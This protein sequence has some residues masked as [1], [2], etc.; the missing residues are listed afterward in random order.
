MPEYYLYTQSDV[1]DTDLLSGDVAFADSY[2]QHALVNIQKLVK[3][4]V[5]R[6]FESLDQAKAQN[7][8]LYNN[9]DYI[10]MISVPETTVE[11]IKEFTFLKQGT[12]LSIKDISKLYP[13]ILAHYY[14]PEDKNKIIIA[15]IKGI[16]NPFEG[17]ATSLTD[18]SSLSTH[19]TLSNPYQL[20][21]QTF[22]AKP[23]ILAILHSIET[24]STLP[25][26][27]KQLAIQSIKKVHQHFNVEDTQSHSAPLTF[28]RQHSGPAI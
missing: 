28:C 2:F 8:T 23:D 24:S 25:T 11:K 16:H 4:S 20:F 22:K 6:L 18:A 3:I 5:I 9:Q 26:E 1:F 7:L 14:P 12:A 27:S 15:Q 13:M 19:S 17:D 21:A 10:V